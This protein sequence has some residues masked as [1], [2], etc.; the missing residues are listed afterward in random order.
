MLIRCPECGF[1]RN[2]NPSQIPD[3]AVMATCPACHKRFRFRDAVQ[4]SQAERQRPLPNLQAPTDR[5]PLIG[6]LE[7]GPEQPGAA[8]P[9]SREAT[10]PVRPE[11]TR[12]TG[13][14]EGGDDPLPP[15]A[16]IPHLPQQERPSAAQS[17]NA[18][19]DP[20]QKTPEEVASAYRAEQEALEREAE[21]KKRDARSLFSGTGKSDLAW[22]TAPLS[23]L[24]VALYHTV[25]QVLFSAPAFFAK[26]GA[27]RAS[28]L[29]ACAFYVLIGLFQSVVQHFWFMAR[30]TEMA[31]M[32]GGQM[33]ATLD[34]VTQNLS[35]PMLFISI[36]PLLLVQLVFYAALFGLMVRL[37]QPDRHDFSVILRVVAYSAAPGILCIVPV[38]GSL[39]ASL[40]FAFCCFIGCKYALNMTWNRTAMAILPLY[41]LSVA[42]S[43][44][45]NKM[46]LGMGMP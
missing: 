41:I 15:G 13:R 5:V 9:L 19:H 1:E 17:T 35:L 33:Q 39:A 26:V 42:L 34:A 18:T 24:P 4:A 30:L 32:Q 14:E 20:D 40:W 21:R 25:L 6:D 23:T 45:V 36:P 43:L 8:A 28:L 2:L 38:V 16:I 27:S 31:S 3:S 22:E 37:V 29:R 12:E 11:P 44:H 10:P 7:D 46:L